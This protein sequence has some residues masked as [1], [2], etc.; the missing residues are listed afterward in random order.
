M[1]RPLKQGIDYY[2]VE[3]DFLKDLKVRKITRACGPVA[4]VV[5]IS[6]LSNIYRDYGY[7]VVWDKD[8]P[9]LI[10]DDVGISEG[11]VEEVVKKALQ[12]GFFEDRLFEEFSILTSHGIQK[13]FLKASERRKC[14]TMV[15]E[16]FLV[17]NNNQVNVNINYVNA[18]NNQVNVNGNPQSKVNKSKVNKSNKNLSGDA[19]VPPQEGKEFDKEG[20]PYKCSKYLADKILL[21]N[22]KAKV[23]K[24]DKGIFKWCI[25]IDRLLRL[26]GKPPE[27]L[28]EVLA[29]AVKDSFWQSN[30]LSTQ[31]FREKYDQLYAKMV[32]Q[33]NGTN[34]GRSL[35]VSRNTGADE[36]KSTLGTI[37]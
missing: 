37:L 19:S 21:V 30:I 2:P 4:P 3:V 5:L 18:R 17:A 13:R 14:I 24:D 34:G 7:Y 1:A 32:S 28:R 11:A 20:I 31:T 8:M 6:L 12:V 15:A 27:E 22:P 29:F 9:F 35:G 10:A 36:N 23:P 33:N 26:D 25:H 16:Y